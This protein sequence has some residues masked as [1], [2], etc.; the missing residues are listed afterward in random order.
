MREALESIIKGET[1]ISL[2]SSI[3]SGQHGPGA[4]RK[5][6]M[7]EELIRNAEGVYRA[8][9]LQKAL[10]LL[11]EGAEGYRTI[12]NDQALAVTLHNLGSLYQETGDYS[13]ALSVLQ[14]AIEVLKRVSD[15]R[16]EA[17]VCASL[18]NVF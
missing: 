9:D 16:G 10:G 4:E 11:K 17:A 8:G 6:R 15:P 12:G 18:G 1:D 13:A 2:F 7:A 14:Q 3:E 5:S